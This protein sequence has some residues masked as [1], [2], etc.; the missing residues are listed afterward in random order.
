MR[1]G[2]L[3]FKLGFRMLVKHPGLTLVGG[4]AMAVAIAIGT[5]FFEFAHDLVNPTLP[6]EEGERIVAIQNWDAAAAAPESRS[7]HEFVAWRDE[8]RSI[9]DFGAYTT[10]ER[11]LITEAGGA[12]PVEIAEI[13]ASAF[14]LVRVPPLVGRPLLPADEQDGAPPVVVIGYGV[15]HSRFGGDPAVIGRTVQLGSSKH[16]VVGVMPDGFAFP[17]QHRV[18][19]PLRANAAVFEPRQGPSIRIFG[20]LAP[21][22]TLDKAQAELTAIA[23]RAPADSA[24]ANRQLRPRVVPYTKSFINDEVVWQAYGMQSIFVMLLIVACANVATLVYART[25]TRESEIVLR[26]ALGAS[27]GRIVTQLFIEA[28]VLAS[29]AAVAGLAAADWALSYGM[30]TFWSVQGDA[31]PFWWDDGLA[32]A[33]LT[34]AGTLTLLAAVITGVVPAIK[35][36]DPS[37]QTA[38]Q[39][40]AAGGSGMRF[41]G[42]WTV[43]IVTQVALSVALLPTVI[44]EAWGAVRAQAAG[45]GFP[46]AQYLSAR[47]E[48]DDVAEADARFEKSYRELERRLAAEPG[49]ASI[50]FG[51]RL[52]GMEH[53]RRAIEIDDLTTQSAPAMSGEVRVASVDVRF[54]DALSTPILSGRAFNAGDL[55]SDQ[56]VA[57]VNQSF[58]RQ[59]LDG[60]NP[61]GRRV[62]YGNRPG[63]AAGQWYEIVGVVTDLEMNPLDSPEDAA[64]LYHAVALGR[65]HPLRM[66]VRV[67]QDPV[68]LA[69]RL[70]SIAADVDP[71][72]RVYDLLPLDDVG[73]ADQIAYRLAA[74]VLVLVASIA[75]LLSTVGIYA[76]MSFTVS[77]RTREIG[78]R[79]ALG[80]DPRHIVGAIFSRALTQLALGVVA[81]TVAAVVFGVVEPD[82]QIARDWPALLAGVATLMLLVGLFSCVV[83]A[84]R[85]LRIQPT[86]ALRQRG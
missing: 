62:R 20:R 54:F 71:T 29:I 56:R 72:L 40:F 67:G 78:I 73:R 69:P 23:S 80:A 53:P 10:P 63:E 48:T 82:D 43:V 70:R 46:A 68:S 26:N 50:T 44:S 9:Q 58:V 76:L 3:D 37:L 75:L 84:L 19:V 34:Y 33:T 55:E 8:V 41:G 42:I 12:E 30:D 36:T 85:G 16:T 45:T 5:A 64:G 11:N 57:I 74:S 61:I 13:S 18:W 52:P 1:S 6:L 38:L 31:R 79:A 4:L 24:D 39:R 35:A 27:R 32:P 2:W 60:R 66:A 51:D 83:P 47:L 7:L 17:V 59:L 77:Q 14:R 81:G 21:D 65:V 15:W 49:V 25:A 22:A 28:L 86:E